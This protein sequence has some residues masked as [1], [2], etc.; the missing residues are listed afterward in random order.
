MLAQSLCES[1]SPCACSD[2]I[3]NLVSSIKRDAT[4]TDVVLSSLTARSDDGQL[5]I[6]VEGVNRP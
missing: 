5:A 4:D 3:I 6:Q 1:E 2:E